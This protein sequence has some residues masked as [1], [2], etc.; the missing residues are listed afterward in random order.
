MKLGAL[1]VTDGSDLSWQ[2]TIGAALDAGLTADEVVDALVVLAPIVGRTRVIA[3]AP[4]VALATGY[5][6]TSELEAR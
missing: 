6:V 1:P 4:K 2:Q 3:V 5:D